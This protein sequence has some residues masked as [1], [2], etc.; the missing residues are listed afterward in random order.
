MTRQEHLAW[1]KQRALAFLPADPVAAM[2]SMLSDL[3]KHPELANHPGILI[4]PVGYAGHHHPGV[5][6][7]WIEGFN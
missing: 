6:Q 5:V 1:A 2:T 7:H 3:S 4:G